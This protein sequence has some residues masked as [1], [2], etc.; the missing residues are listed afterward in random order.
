MQVT[1]EWVGGIVIARVKGRVDG[2]NS[3]QFWK[4]LRAAIGEGDQSVIVDLADLR[5]ISSSGLRVFMLVSKERRIQH[6]GMALCSLSDSVEQ[7]FGITGIDKIIPIYESRSDAIAA[8][9]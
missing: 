9:G 5:Y 1:A 2:S 7:V 6:R 8:H 3:I 4:E